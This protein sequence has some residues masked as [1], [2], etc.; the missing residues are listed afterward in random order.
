M[1]LLTSRASRLRAKKVLP[2]LVVAVV[3]VLV[4]LSAFGSQSANEEAFA[5]NIYWPSPSNYYSGVAP[6]NVYLR[7][8]YTGPNVGNYTY[9]VTY[10]SSSGAE[11]AARGNVLVSR[12]SPFT[13]YGL[14]PVPP[15]AIVTAKAEV[16]RGAV[17]QHN[18]IYFKSIQL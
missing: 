13:A 5:F 1:K 8:N 2:L 4:G 17:S 11:I 6:P 12:L 10:N 15:G 16:Y 9:I 3:A 7:I 18:L 14:I